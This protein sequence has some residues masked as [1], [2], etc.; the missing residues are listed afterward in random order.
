[1]SKLTQE[2]FNDGYGS[3]L[4]AGEFNETQDSISVY[5]GEEY[6]RLTLAGKARLTE[7]YGIFSWTSDSFRGGQ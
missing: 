7:F 2:D 1:M 5:S 6:G 4:S 3:I